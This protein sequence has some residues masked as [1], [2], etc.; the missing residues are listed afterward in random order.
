MGMMFS[1]AQGR[2]RMIADPQGRGFV[3]VKVTKIVPGNASLQPGLIS[4]MQTEF[5]EATSREYG[6]QMA[7]AITAAVGVKRNDSEIQA[8][9]QRIVGG[10]G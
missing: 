9:R 8:A 4:Q 10:G 6:E 5:Q 1:L 2:S 3:I 7:R